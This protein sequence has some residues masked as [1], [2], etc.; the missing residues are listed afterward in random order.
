MENYY[1]KQAGDGLPL[2]VF[3]GVR[4]QRGY[5]FFGRIFKTHVLPILKY[6]GSQALDTGKAIFN[7]IKTSATNRVLDKVQ[8]VASE[9][10]KRK[11]KL[12]VSDQVGEGIKR[13]RISKRHIDRTLFNFL[14]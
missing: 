7:D 6:L 13:P 2:Q 4:Y 8:E 11:R 12:S 10:I 3:S 14:R 9:V 1:L 5:G